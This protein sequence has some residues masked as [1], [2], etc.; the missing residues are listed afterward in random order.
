MRRKIRFL[1]LA[2]SLLA[3]LVG[4]IVAV[5]F[6]LPTPEPSRS[7][8]DFAK[9]ALALS[10]VKKRVEAEKSKISAG[11]EAHPLVLELSA[12]ERLQVYENSGGL[13]RQV[14]LRDD[15]S[16]AVLAVISPKQPSNTSHSVEVNISFVPRQ[17]EDGQ[18]EWDCFGRPI[19]ALP[20]FCTELR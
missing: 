9:V 2:F 20:R 18:F 7:F 3:V 11:R 13:I 5:T 8:M 14:S 4:G 15:G 12:E 17:K 19:S 10:G 1:V 16:I 6:F